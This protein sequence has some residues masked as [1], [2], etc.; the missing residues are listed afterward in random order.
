M[1]NTYNPKPN[2]YHN[3][4]HYDLRKLSVITTYDYNYY[5][6]YDLEIFHN[7]HYDV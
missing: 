2:N 6:H 5:H 1:Q 7:L 3:H 4:C